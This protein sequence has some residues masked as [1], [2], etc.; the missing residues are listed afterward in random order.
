MRVSSAQRLGCAGQASTTGARTT[1]TTPAIP[2]TP[3]PC[4]PPEPPRRHRRP[5]LP[6]P[7]VRTPARRLAG[8]PVP[9]SDAE[10]QARRD[11]DTAAITT[12]IKQLDTVQNAQITALEE[13]PADPAAAMRSRIRDR[14]AELHDQRQQAETQLAA[15]TDATLQALPAILNPS[16][17]GHHDTANDTPAGLTPMGN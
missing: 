15:L 1:P 16:Q 3:A 7:R 4:R 12:R 5:V 11:A 17:D 9:A 8:H 10:A 6:R 14:V 2:T 13:I